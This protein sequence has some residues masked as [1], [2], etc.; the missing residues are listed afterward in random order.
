[1]NNY[2]RD[3]SRQVMA[4][5]PDPESRSSA[6]PEPVLSGRV[7]A[8]RGTVVDV[9]FRS[10]LP[11]PGAS[12]RCQ[13][14]G[15][16]WITVVVQVHLDRSAVRTIAIEPTRALR[17][18]SCVEWD[19]RSLSVPVGE[20]LLA[21]VIDLQGRPID[22]GPTSVDTTLKPVH[23]APPGAAPTHEQHR[24]LSDGIKVIDLLCPFL[25][26]GRA[27]VFGGA[28]VGK[29]IVDIAG[30]ARRHRRIV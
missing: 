28:G 4:V 17:R 10:G 3:R 16:R 29:T 15:E 26:G 20:A 12:L 1:M 18:G 24:N 14:E 8:V 13:L 19:G 7:C 21:R 22:A 6:A 30:G 9:A 5:R 2:D 23:R 11:T 25:S 27:A